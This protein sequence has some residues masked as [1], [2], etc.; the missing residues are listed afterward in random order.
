MRVDECPGV[1][2]TVATHVEPLVI[3]GLNLCSRESERL[4]ISTSEQQLTVG[5]EHIGVSPMNAVV[6]PLVLFHQCQV[7]G[8][9]SALIGLVKLTFN[10]EVSVTD[11]V[12][13]QRYGVGRISMHADAC[14]IAI[15]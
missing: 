14:H 2:L 8:H 10:A 1:A 3:V 4:F 13:A 6:R 15:G 7:V 12:I 11:G 5:N 9:Q